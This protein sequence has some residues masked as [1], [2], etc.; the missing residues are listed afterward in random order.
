MFSEV[1]KG[2]GS[3][4][5]YGFVIAAICW[6][7]FIFYSPWF[8]IPALIGNGLQISRIIEQ[9]RESNARPSD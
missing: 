6:A 3:R 5:I 7:L 4:A 2:I 1:V 8:A 9:V